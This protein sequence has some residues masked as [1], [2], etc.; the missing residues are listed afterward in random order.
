M[1]GWFDPSRLKNHMQQAVG[2][3]IIGQDFDLK[4]KARIYGHI[5]IQQYRTI[6]N[7]MTPPPHTDLKLKQVYG[8]NQMKRYYESEFSL[9][10]ETR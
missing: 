9:D 6:K 2:H 10:L 4:A 5:F 1:T 3:G 8:R 7:E